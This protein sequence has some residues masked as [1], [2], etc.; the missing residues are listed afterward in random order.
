MYDILFNFI[1][2]IILKIT[3]TSLEML[4]DHSNVRP[5]GTLF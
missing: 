4:L 5:L 3:K 1:K 2:N